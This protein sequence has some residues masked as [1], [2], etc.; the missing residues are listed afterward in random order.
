[1]GSILTI[2]LNL[3]VEQSNSLRALQTSFAEVC[4]TLTP[5]VQQT[6]CWNRVGLHHMAYRTLR[7]RFPQLG[8]QMVCN[9]IYSVSRACRQVYQNPNSP[10]F[11]GKR[12]DAIIPLLRFSDTAPVYFDKHT[13][14]IKDN[15]LSM[16]TLDG[17]IRFQINLS[18]TDKAR[19]HTEK[20]REIVLFHGSEAIQ[21]SFVFGEKDADP[22]DE[23]PEYILL[24]APDVDSESAVLDSIESHS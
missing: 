13:L 15:E 12:S 3:S 16:F 2:N 5:I 11:I 17:R 20:L 14:S 6:R 8:S 19:F 23:L 7:E 10:Y 22:T 18:D 1:M 9:A 4:N 24:M 21:L